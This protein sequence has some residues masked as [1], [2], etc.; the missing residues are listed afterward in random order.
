M[1]DPQTAVR[2]VSSP[3]AV[4]AKP[5]AG[6]P[7]LPRHVRLSF[8]ETGPVGFRRTYYGVDVFEGAYR[9]RGDDVLAGGPGDD[10]L[11]GGT[12]RDVLEGG[13]GSDTCGPDATDGCEVVGRALR[14]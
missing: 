9:G 3:R 10:R 1:V 12:G 2:T 11:R 8:Q 7:H 5:A 14:P 6:S 13:E 4:V